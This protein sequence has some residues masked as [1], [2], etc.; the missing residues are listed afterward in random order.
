MRGGR[1]LARRQALQLLF[2]AEACG[3]S[4]ADV[5]D[6]GEY[7]LEEGPLD[8]YAE[9]IARGAGG[10]LPE[11]DRAIG[12]RSEGWAVSRMP[13]V[14]RNILRLAAYEMIAVDEVDVAV[15]INEAV[16]LAK[17]FGTDESPRFVNGLLG[18]LAD[19]LEAGQDVLAGPKEAGGGT[20]PQVE[21]DEPEAEQ[22]SPEP[23]AEAATTGADEA[24]GADGLAE[25]IGAGTDGESRVAA[26]E[27]AEA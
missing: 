11:L 23:A 13:A 14:D 22:G 5:I 6:G 18:R 10:L 26:V 17:V 12:S 27:D 3:R 8:E 19:D 1:S 20:A 4:V 24:D 15:A 7:A 21:E 9:Q 16:D 25:V 2:Q